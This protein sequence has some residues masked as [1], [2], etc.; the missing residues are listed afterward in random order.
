MRRSVLEDN[1]EERI[2]ENSEKRKEMET[3][4]T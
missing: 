2:V 3:I 4:R 1:E